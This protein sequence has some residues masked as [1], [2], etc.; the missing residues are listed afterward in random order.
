MRENQNTLRRSLRLAALALLFCPAFL[1]RCASIMTP[2]GGPKDTLP[3]VIIAMEPGNNT[4]HFSAKKIYIEFDEFVQLKDQ[5][6]EFYTSPEM[7]YKPRLSIRGRGVVVQL[8]DT[9]LE[10][11]TYALNFG[12][13]IRDNN[14]G[15]PLYSMRYVFSTG[16]EIDSMICSGYTADSYKADSVGR[17]FILFYPADSVELHPDYD[18]TVFNYKPAAIARAETN[19]I[20]IAQNLKPIDYL[21]YAYEDTNNN[22]IYD[23]ATDQV[24]FLSGRYNPATLPD[25]AIWYDSLR[26]YVTAEPQ[27]YFRMFKDVTFMR[28]YLKQSERP[29]QHKAILYFN[30]ARPQIDSIRFDSIPR[31]RVILEPL[32]IGRDTLALWFDLPSAELPDTI[33]GT[34]TYLKHDSL[35]TLQPVT[36]NLRLAWRHIESKEE[37]E[38]EKL[39][40]ER[41]KAE[42]AGEEWQEPEKPSTFTY[43]LSATGSVTPE[44]KLWIDFDYPLTRMDS[45]AITLSEQF[46]KQDPVQVP[47]HLRRDTFNLRRWHLDAR[48]QE[49]AQYTLV[50]PKGSL[51]DLAG[52][53]NDSTGVSFTGVDPEKF[54][55]FLIHFKGRSDTTAYVV[56]LLNASGK[57]IEEKNNI[58]SGDVTFRY[59]AAGDVQ[60]RIIEDQNGNGI[61]DTGNLIERR[62]PERAEYYVNDQGESTF[63][64]KENWENELTMDMNVTFAP[65]TMQS[66]IELLDEREEQRLKKWEEEQAEK[67][68]KQQGQQQQGQGGF[69][70]GGL[71]SGGN[72]GSRGNSGTN[73]GGMN[74]NQGMN[75]NPMRR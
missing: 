43:K 45:T 35:N 41:K 63:A 75:Q 5:Q 30:A 27:L 53:E 68:R 51:A 55:T 33:K 42:E 48:W 21:V 44:S 7:K 23:P 3:P 39:E 70:F 14:E 13:A 6:K 16:S 71:N 64:A 40:R 61:W 28:Q 59:V 69:G 8:R 46:D 73:S 22:M 17:S 26:H 2:E 49:K 36:E 1:W 67:R 38:R 72:S 60:F 20:F 57:V 34:I 47:L 24:G 10:N 65:V 37:K 18:S 11:T 4:T 50:M 52:Q 19:G 54:S 56:Q 62:E 25:F 9:L 12:S 74:R 31:E 32:T 66:L 15:N 29:A 58:H